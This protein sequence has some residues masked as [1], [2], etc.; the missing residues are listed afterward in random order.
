MP[1]GK[2][3]RNRRTVYLPRK[4]RRRPKALTA[5]AKKQVTRIARKEAGKA[6]A[7]TYY[8][9]TVGSYTALGEVSTYRN[10]GGTLLPLT[11]NPGQNRLDLNPCPRYDEDTHGADLVGKRIG[12]DIW[13]KGFKM[14]GLLSVT[15]SNQMTEQRVRM[16]L[17]SARRPV[18]A[19]HA[20]PALTADY[21]ANVL[22]N[23]LN[24][25]MKDEEQRELYAKVRVLATKE[26]TL[27]PKMKADINRPWSFTHWF[28]KPKREQYDPQDAAG[29]FPLR[30]SYFFLM[31]TDRDH[32]GGANAVSVVYDCRKYYFTE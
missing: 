24:G 9:N 18:T 2:R 26:I 5:A 7:S 20:G 32:S 31:W 29:V 1:L 16:A 12:D 6:R 11:S 14:Q 25:S 3:K 10:Q 22:Y 30:Y 21:P 4:R 19:D 28:K 8:D 13:I 17:V 15:A 23:D 27:H